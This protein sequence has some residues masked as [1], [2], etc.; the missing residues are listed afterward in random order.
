LA[1]IN[2]SVVS[3]HF[4]FGIRKSSGYFIVAHSL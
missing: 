4:E 2:R 3:P 1:T